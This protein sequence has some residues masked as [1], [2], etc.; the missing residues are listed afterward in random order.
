MDSPVLSCL[1]AQE[2]NSIQVAT[3]MSQGSQ[4]ATGGSVGEGNF[5][6]FP[7]GKGVGR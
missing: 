5:V 3:A 7:W 6:P 4:A 2:C 1:T